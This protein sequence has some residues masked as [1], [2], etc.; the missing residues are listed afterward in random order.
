MF[1]LEPPK[2]QKKEASFLDESQVQKLLDLLDKEPITY[3]TMI[4]LLLHTGMRRGELCGLEWNDIDLDAGLL[5]IQR[6]SLYL[7]EKGVFMDDTK[8][9]SSKRV[10]KLT[11]DAVQLLRRYRS[12]QGRERLRLGDQWVDTWEDHPRLFT[13]WNGKPLHPS[14]VTG[15]FHDFVERSGLPP[16]SIH[17]LRHPYVRL[18]PKSLELNYR[19]FFF[20]LLCHK[21]FQYPIKFQFRE[22]LVLPLRGT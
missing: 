11:P 4:T 1:A 20:P 17:S 14:T 5:D 13:T 6:S 8:N 21:A 3:R 2:V 16:V 10:L 9:N 7:P 22:W 12:W 19:G 18:R 15:W